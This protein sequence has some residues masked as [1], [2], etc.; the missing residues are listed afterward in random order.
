MV[1]TIVIGVLIAV[2]A[3][4]VIYKKAKDIKKGKFCSCGCSE[5]A[6]FCHEKKNKI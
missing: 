3:S 5:C 6:S 4:V 2:Y 1:A